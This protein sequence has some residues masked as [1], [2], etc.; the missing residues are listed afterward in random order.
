MNNY[1]KNEIIKIISSF[2]IIVNINIDEDMIIIKIK[3]KNIKLKFLNLNK[4]L[5]TKKFYCKS[6]K[7]HDDVYIS[8]HRLKEKENNSR[9]K[10]NFIPI[11]LFIIVIILVMIDG[12]YKT[13]NI[14]SI[15]N[16]GDPYNIA[17]IYTISL[18]GIIGTHEIGHLVIARINS[19]KTTWPYFIPGIPIFGIPTFGAFIRS[20]RNITNKE[21]L[22]DIAIAGPIAGLII[23]VIV[24]IYGAYNAPIIDIE[25]T[26]GITDSYLVNYKKSILMFIILEIFGKGADVY[27]LMTPIL[28][29]SW[30]GFLI[31]FLNLLPA[32]QLDGGHIIRSMFSKKIYVIMTYISILLLFM[33]GYFMMAIIILL[34]STKNYKIEILDGVSEISSNRKKIYIITIVLIIICAPLPYIKLF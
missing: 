15:I 1:Q 4:I 24:T 25:L 22:F 21:I 29:A 33:L 23:T 12:Y 6:K 13:I 3:N 10:S 11:T 20:N 7:I 17:I 2:F 27:V 8:I 16:I 32:W 30:L 28:F 34:F 5:I 9:Y 18:L 19:I 31:T 26:K 14:N